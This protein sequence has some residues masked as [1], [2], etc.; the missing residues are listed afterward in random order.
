MKRSGFPETL[1][2]HKAKVTENE[3]PAHLVRERTT[4]FI[5]EDIQVD[6]AFV[7]DVTGS[8]QDEM[9]SVINALTDFIDE[10]DTSTAPLMA[11]LTF[12]DEVKVA[13]FTQD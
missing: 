12:G 1:I 4:I 7:I 6:L 2:L 10:I 13:A 5:P 11:L 3:Y 9:N 8:M